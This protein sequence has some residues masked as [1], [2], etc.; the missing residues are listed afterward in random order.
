MNLIFSL[1]EAEVV[2]AEP[3]EIQAYSDSD[4]IGKISFSRQKI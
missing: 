4:Y 1:N 2:G 3:E